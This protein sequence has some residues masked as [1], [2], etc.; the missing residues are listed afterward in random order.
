[1]V[2]V[3]GGSR[4]SHDVHRFIHHSSSIKLTRALPPIPHI[5]LCDRCGL[6][7]YLESSPTTMPLYK[8]MGFTIL[9]EKIV[10]KKEVLNTDA[11]IEVPLMVR[12]PSFAGMNFYEL[13]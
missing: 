1:V 7:L 9:K 12:M 8:K 11:D 13:A 5:D 10:H 2:E 4:E 3:L 6:P